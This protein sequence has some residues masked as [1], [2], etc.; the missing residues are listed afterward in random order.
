MTDGLSNINAENT[1]KEAELAKKEGTHVISIGIG[2]FDPF[3]INA[4]ATEPASKNAYV[5]DSFDRLFNISDRL[6]SATCR[7]NSLFL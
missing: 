1:L 6:V 3:E 7:G 5:I 2:S 4:M